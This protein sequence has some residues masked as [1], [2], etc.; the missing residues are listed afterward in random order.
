VNLCKQFFLQNI[1]FVNFTA[2]T[3]TFQFDSLQFTNLN[4]HAQNKYT[5]GLKRSL[6]I[7]VII[8]SAPI[9]FFVILILT[10]ACCLDGN[11]PLYSQWRVGRNGR[12]F[13]CWKFRTM[14][15]NN[16]KIL[17]QY[18][19][20]NPAA[21][22]EWQSFRKLKNDPRIT[23]IGLFLRQTS[24]DE[25][26]QL[27]NIL[28]GEMSIVGPRP[29]VPDELVKYGDAIQHYLALRPGLTGLWQTSGRN[30]I[31]YDNRVALD[32]KYLLT[33]SFV[34]D[35]KIIFRTFGAVLSRTGF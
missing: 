26:P 30:D 10:I 2:D 14:V 31:G 9:T 7:S 6:D 18:L 4:P 24:L 28:R 22:L 17:E 32:V 12:L 33:M 15:P 1:H 13:R 8:F 11:A 23:R 34:L 16:Q 19:L 20:K 35:I 5:I 21:R 25:L 29:I 3:M 27:Y